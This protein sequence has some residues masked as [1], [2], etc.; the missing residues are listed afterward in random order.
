MANTFCVDAECYVFQKCD[1]DNPSRVIHAALVSKTFGLDKTNADTI[2]DDLLDGELTGQVKIIRNI[3]GEKPRPETQ[4]LDGFGRRPVKV[5]NS[6]HTINYQD[7]YAIENQDFYNTI[8]FASQNYD[9]YYF[10]DGYIW[11]ASGNLITFYGDPVLT[12]GPNDL[13]MTEATIKWTA[14]TSPTAS[15]FDTDV[16]EE[17]LYYEITPGSYPSGQITMT[18]DAV[19]S[20]SLTAALSQ[21]VANSCSLIWSIENNSDPDKLEAVINSASGV[22]DL[23]GQ[24]AGTGV[25]TFDVVVKNDCGGCVQGSFKFTVTL[26]A[27]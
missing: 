11:D 2:L 8:K 20:D 14:K 1:S 6:T 25:V 16:L 18:A 7:Q 23:T 24:D 26:T 19:I 4:E 10:T 17:G 9:L 12:S 3:R 15:A 21:Y 5:G 27:A 22:L 13:V